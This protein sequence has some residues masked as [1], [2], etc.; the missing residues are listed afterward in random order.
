[1]PAMLRLLPMSLYVTNPG[2]VAMLI[3]N[4]RNDTFVVYGLGQ[5]GGLKASSHGVAYAES[6]TSWRKIE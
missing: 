1:M 4:S 2:Q 5:Y 3:G 6:N